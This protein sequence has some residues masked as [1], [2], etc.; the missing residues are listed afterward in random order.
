MYV[1]NYSNK[2]LFEKEDYLHC[3]MTI[4][5]ADYNTWGV[6]NTMNMET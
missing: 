3:C 1:N 4:L 2:Q 5:L 6:V